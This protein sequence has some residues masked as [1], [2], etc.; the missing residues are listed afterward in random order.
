MQK[1][2]NHILHMYMIYNMYSTHILYVL[3][4]FWHYWQLENS[5]IFT[6]FHLHLME[7]D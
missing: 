2:T 6:V 1:A 3:I 4:E 7:I 5:F